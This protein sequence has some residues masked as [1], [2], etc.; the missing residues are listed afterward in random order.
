ML[1]KNSVTLVQIDDAVSDMIS[2]NRSQSPV[3]RAEIPEMIPCIK[4][5]AIP[6]TNLIC[7]HVVDATACKVGHKTF[8]IPITIGAKVLNNST[9][10]FNAKSTAN[11]IPSNTF[12]TT[13]PIASKIIAPSVSHHDLIFSNC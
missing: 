6:M 9:T 1:V 12:F 4:S 8:Q 10:N 2:P 7:S 3:I 11:L 13:I 5:I